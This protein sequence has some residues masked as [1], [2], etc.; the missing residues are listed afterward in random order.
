MFQHVAY[1]ISLSTVQKM[2]EEFFGVHL[3]FNEVHMFKTLMARYY[4]DPF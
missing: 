3:F 2:C 1:Q 4:R